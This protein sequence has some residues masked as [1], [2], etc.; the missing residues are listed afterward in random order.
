V[1]AAVA[2]KLAGKQQPQQ[3]KKK[4]K[5]LV[6]YCWVHHKFGKTARKCDN[7]AECMWEN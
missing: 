7:P 5:K 1:L 3:Q 2:G 4:N 6:T